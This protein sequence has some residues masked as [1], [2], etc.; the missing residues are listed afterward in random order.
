VSLWFLA[1]GV[2]I[3]AALGVAAELAARAWL[4][5]YGRYYVWPPHARL[6]LSTDREAVPELEPLVRVEFN[7]E[8]ERGGPPPRDWSDAFR[9]L[10][11]GGSTAECWFLDQPSTWPQV[12][13]GA[14]EEPASLAK[15]GVSRVHVGSIARSLVACEHVDR[16]V[17]QVL[18]RYERLDV[19]VLM[20]GASDLVHWLEKGTPTRIDRDEISL[21]SMFSEH[22]E[23]PFGWSRSTLALKRVASDLRRRLLR[24]IARRRNVGR[25][26][27]QARLARAQ[28]KEIIRSVPDPTPM[29]DRLEKNLR[30]LIEHAR[31]RAKRVIVARQ[32]WLEKEFTAEEQKHLWMFGAGRVH[33][34]AVTAYYAHDLVWKL[35]RKVDERVTRAAADLGVESVDLRPVVPPTFELWYDEMHHNARGC[36]KIGRAL[37]RVI[38]RE[39]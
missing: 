26:I 22:P 19:I 14:L 16:M 20:V 33:S 6:H 8:G 34:E 24:P 11:A 39:T 29:L 37:A 15:L 9:V 7:A 17:E 5:R 35:M 23:G 2:A 13:Q 28:A 32:P 25:R 30:S 38:L 1:G 36:E 18:P 4:A 31:A 21:E 10:V 12:I 27:A 3:L